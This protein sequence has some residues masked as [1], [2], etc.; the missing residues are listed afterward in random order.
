MPSCR[1]LS[2]RAGGWAIQGADPVDSEQ[3]ALLDRFDSLTRL[4]WMPVA[5]ARR[6]NEEEAAVMFGPVEPVWR[7][8]DRH[9]PGPSGVIRTRIYR[10]TEDYR[11]PVLVYFHGG[12]W[13]VGSLASHDGVAR[14]LARYG[15]CLVIS[16]DYR[17]A[18]EHRFPAAVE[19]ALAAT[20]WVQKHA[21][22]IGGNA[23]LIAVA[24]DSSGGNLA[25]VVA[26]HA[27]DQGLDLAMQLLVYPALD[28]DLET[29]GD[30]GWWLRQYL[31]T[32]ADAM[33]P[34]ASPLRAGDLHGVARALVLSCGLDP[35]QAQA[36][37][38]VR[39]LGE[40]GVRAEHIHYPDL[41]HG[42]Y[43]MPGVLPGA[44]RMLEDSAS[45]LA[46]AFGVRS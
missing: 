28:C 13:V 4:P 9:L 36:E 1:G 15:R 34:D 17:L 39:R 31:R 2:A 3:R 18:P 46:G 29:A 24:G 14:F 40:A 8:D 21:S 41:I 33:D 7:V 32:E 43:R 44:R 38:Y 16:I 26:R 19:D 22:E 12:G 5:A 45:A 6:V 27:R 20:S 37:A 11:L 30:D 42:A 35:L 10:P 25:A 23:G